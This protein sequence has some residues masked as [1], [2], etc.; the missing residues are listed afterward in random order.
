MMDIVIAGGGV[1]GLATAW[2][3]Q[4]RGLSVT[5]ID[6]A[7]ASKASHVSA[8]M[9]PPGNEQ[10]YDQPELLAL[11]LASRD[12]YPSFAAELEEFAPS[13]YR[14]DGVLD[15]AFDD[16]ALHT[17]DHQH[18]FQKSLGIAV[19][20]V[21]A[22]ECA[23]LQPAFAPALGGLLSPDDG[24]IDPRVMTAALQT[25]LKKLGGT[26][27]HERVIRVDG[28]TVLLGDGG[29]V[30]FDRLVL[31]A[32]CWTHR[33]EGLPKGAI[34]E[35]R[36]VKGQILRLHS[37]PP[38]LNLTARALSGGS[39]LYL[40]PR[41]DGE[42]VVGATYEERG[43]DETVTAAGTN[44]LL[45]RAAAVLPGAGDLRF[46]EI[47]ASLRPGSPDDLPVIGPTAVPDV[48]LASGHFRMGVQLSPVTAE[49][50]AAHLTGTAVPDPAVPFSPL[51]FGG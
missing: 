35:I 51:R 42:L 23:R 50:M 30:P 7:P 32:G 14:R 43:Y 8:G 1:I 9:L 19:E 49:A 46:A 17:L 20:R 6:P 26:V 47:S 12:L 40:V 28:H 5:V 10:L 16:D 39:S 15:A 4:Q 34:P 33:I 38:L 21:S 11:Y 41:L 48:Y 18:A 36:P 31:A 29:V 2:R 25:A 45:T 13:G 3:A 24:A 44:E 27:V 37:D 22:E